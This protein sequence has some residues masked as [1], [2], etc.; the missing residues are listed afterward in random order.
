MPS[1]TDTWRL[2]TEIAKTGCDVQRILLQAEDQCEVQ[3]LPES[4]IQKPFQLFYRSQM[5]L[6]FSLLTSTSIEQ[7]FLRAAP[8]GFLCYC[9]RL[10]DAALP[11]HL[12]AVPRPCLRKF[13][14]V[15]RVVGR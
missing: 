7:R 14:A 9:R 3:Y 2:V 1:S 11:F 15:A 4:K 10:A 5:S 12:V 13:S 8:A 6:Q